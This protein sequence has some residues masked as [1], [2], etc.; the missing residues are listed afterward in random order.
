[1]GKGALATPAE[2]LVVVVSKSLIILTK[3]L[4]V[5]TEALVVLTKALVIL[6]KPL[7][8]LPETLVVESLVVV[9]EALTVCIVVAKQ[10]AKKFYVC[11]IVVFILCLSLPSSTGVWVEAVVI[12]SSSS[13]EPTEELL[14]RVFLVLSI[15]PSPA[16][17]ALLVSSWKEEFLVSVVAELSLPLS[18]SAA[19]GVA[20]TSSS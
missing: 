13:K 20:S 9:V 10:T 19:V 8:I 14:V 6:T 4:V 2:Y 7:V 3:S 12:S 17:A 15:P 1:M 16:I 5:L 18:S 11:P